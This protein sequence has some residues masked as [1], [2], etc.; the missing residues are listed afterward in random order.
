MGQQLEVLVLD[1]NKEKERVSLGLK[2]TQKNPW[3]QIVERFPAG[4]TLA[5]NHSY[6]PGAG[7]SVGSMIPFPEYRH[8]AEV[9]AQINKYCVDTAFLRSIDRRTAKDKVS[10]A[11][12]PE[13]RVDYILTTG[14]NWRSPIGSF[15]LVVDKGKASNLVS[16]CET[17]VRQISPT[18]FEVRHS[19]WTPTSDLHVLIIEPPH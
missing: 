4:Q 10:G 15:R 11:E 16:F 7:G 9:K 8:T 6:I 3:D 14:A 2:Q 1:I 12:M 5:V 19:N 18:Q 13:R 17:G